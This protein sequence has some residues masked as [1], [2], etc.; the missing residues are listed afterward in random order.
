MKLARFFS[1]ASGNELP[2]HTAPRV[3]INKENTMIQA[4]ENTVDVNVSRSGSIFLF[5]LNTDAAESWVEEN[6]QAESWQWLGGRL[7][8]DHGFAHALVQGMQDAGLVVE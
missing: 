1:P 3:K 7:C 5:D 6:V 4:T 2:P 8:V